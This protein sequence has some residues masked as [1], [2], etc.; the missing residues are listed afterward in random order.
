M[1]IQRKHI[2]ASASLLLVSALLT[3][4]CAENE[5]TLFIRGALKIPTE[6][7]EVTSDP[8]SIMLTRGIL[9][10]ALAPEYHAS[11]LIGNQLVRRGNTA[12]LRTETSRVE[13][14]E[15]DVEVIDITGESLTSFRVPAAG[16][17]D[18]GASTEP[19]YGFASI[20]LVDAV[21]SQA[22]LKESAATN[23]IQEVVA[24]VIV[25]G[26]TLGGL[27]VETG[28]W[29]F[30]ISVCNRC[31]LSFPAEAD[32]TTKAGLDCDNR[33]D[34]PVNC[35]IGMDAPVDCRSCSGTSNACNP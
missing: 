3:Q 22:L 17:V 27:E 5:S 28:T 35:R 8:A 15:A 32:D 13:F 1:N 34:A 7:C 12:T 11:L 6:T 10:A 31:L 9:D 14:T 18:P 24:N 2:G 26:R 16:F 25:R 30:P 29:S 33:T 19:G 21:T 23:Q 4:G 20:V